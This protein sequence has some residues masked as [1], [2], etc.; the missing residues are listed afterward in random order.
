MCA[1]VRMRRCECGGSLRTVCACWSVRAC[2]VAVGREGSL[3]QTQ[4][5]GR[6][7]C[8]RSLL[9][10]WGW[11]GG[12][13]WPGLWGAVQAASTLLL[14]WRPGVRPSPVPG[15]L[16]WE[17]LGLRRPGGRPRGVPWGSRVKLRKLTGV[18]WG[19]GHHTGPWLETAGSVF[20]MKKLCSSRDKNSAAC[21]VYEDMSRSRCNTLS[22]PNQYQ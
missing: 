15:R 20:Q 4:S 5:L 19:L 22:S 1:R 21:V 9:F 17:A 6:G 18:G 3:R 10:V 13:A 12:P 16:C 8:P 2:C 14:Q 7:P 11:S